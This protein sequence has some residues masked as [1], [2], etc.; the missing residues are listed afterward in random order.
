MAGSRLIKLDAA[1][2]KL[3]CHVETLR[4]R[5]RSGQ[6]KAH[7]GP[8]GAYFLRTDSLERLLAHNARGLRAPIA[9]DFGTGVAKVTHAFGRGARTEASCG[10]SPAMRHRVT[11]Y[12][13]QHIPRDEGSRWRTPT[14]KGFS[15]YCAP[16]RVD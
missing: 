14:L 7:R 5:I 16:T 10:T 9:R 13:A 6:L 12:A 8:H 3:G 4:I 15:T 1:A 2:S 11:A